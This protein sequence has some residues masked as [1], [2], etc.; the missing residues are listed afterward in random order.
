MTTWLLSATYRFR[1]EKLEEEEKDKNVET[2][3]LPDTDELVALHGDGVEPDI[4]RFDSHTCEPKMLLELDRK[5]STHFCNV[6]FLR[7]PRTMV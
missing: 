5:N 6:F 4:G 2:D 3:L 1:G 7:K